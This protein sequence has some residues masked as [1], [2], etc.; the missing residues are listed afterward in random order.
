MGQKINS[1][2]LRL[3]VNRFWNSSWYNNNPFISYNNSGLLHEDFLIHTY[4]NGVLNSLD[5]ICETPLIKRTAGKIYIQLAFY[6]KPQRFF[7]YTNIKKKYQRF[8]KKKLK[9]L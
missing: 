9:D 7:Q 5:L 2:A 4:L 3:G 8:R 6:K 1:T